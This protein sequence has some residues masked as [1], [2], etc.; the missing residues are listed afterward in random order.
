MAITSRPAFIGQKVTTTSGVSQ[1]FAIPAGSQGFWLNMSAAGFV[2]VSGNNTVINPMN[3]TNSDPVAAGL[4]GPF[5]FSQG[6]DRYVH[7]GGDGGTPV[8]TIT[9]V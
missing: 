3:A 1:A 6:Q 2:L 7:V 5:V 9:F 8:A 4:Y